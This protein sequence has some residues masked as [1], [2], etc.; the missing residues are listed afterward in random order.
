MWPTVPK[1]NSS[2]EAL[3]DALSYKL[4]L[5]CSIHQS[6]N[7]ISVAMIFIENSC[8]P[9][10]AACVMMRRVHSLDSHYLK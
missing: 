8:Q 6:I 5:C 4:W 2:I 1:P 9:V 7:V 3:A 10:T